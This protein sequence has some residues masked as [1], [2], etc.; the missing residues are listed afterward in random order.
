MRRLEMREMYV[1]ISD[2]LAKPFRVARAKRFD[3]LNM[4]GFTAPF[5]PLVRLIDQFKSTRP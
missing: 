4:F 3:E 5:A 1:V 2:K